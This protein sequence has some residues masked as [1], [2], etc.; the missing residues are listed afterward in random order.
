VSAV[1][2]TVDFV[3]DIVD[4]SINEK[5]E[6]FIVLV[7]V[8]RIANS[9]DTP[10]ESERLF[11][12]VTIGIDPNEPDKTRLLIT[13][14]SGGSATVSEGTTGW[15]LSLMIEAYPPEYDIEVSVAAGGTSTNP[16]MAGVDYNLSETSVTLTPGTSEYRVSLEI[17]NDEVPEPISESFLVTFS[18]M[19]ETV[20]FRP[21]AFVT[22]TIE[23]ND[24]LMM[25][26]SSSQLEIREGES[27]VARF[28]IMS[29]P[30]I[31]VSLSGSLAHASGQKTTA[32]GTEIPSPQSFSLSQTNRM[33]EF[34]VTIPQN[35]FITVKEREF[36]LTVQDIESMSNLYDVSQMYLRVTIK[37]NDT[38]IDV[39]IRDV[40]PDQP[41]RVRE[42]ESFTFTVGFLDDSV[43]LDDDFVL[44]YSLKINSNGPDEAT[45]FVTT[46][47]SD[48]LLTSTMRSRD[49][50][51]ETK[52][53]DKVEEKREF[54]INMELTT[55]FHPP[56]LVKFR[57]GSDFMVVII[58]DDDIDPPIKP[59]VNTV[60]V[61][62]VEDGKGFEISWTKNSSLVQ[63]V[64]TYRVEITFPAQGRIAEF[65]TSTTVDSKTT[66]LT[67]PYKQNGEDY[68]N[69]NITVVVCAVNSVG[70]TCSEEVYHKGIERGGTGQQGGS[71][72]SDGGIAAIVI[73]L[74]LLLCIG[75]L[76]LVLLLIYLYHPYGWRSYDPTKEEEKNGE[77]F[78]EARNE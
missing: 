49:I 28:F 57:A 72:V 18:V 31:D 74:L 30:T 10:E 22:I 73:V 13:A 47:I 40:S 6:Q 50:L 45:N 62:D 60:V 77:E 61:V 4:D 66:F 8:I 23:D 46:E 27:A 3:I 59:L 38:N 51:I 12:T 63:P 69:A 19:E 44:G 26:F 55:D 35:D 34:T 17:V 41:R 39:G 33:Y 67:V 75:I 25:G 24:R 1:R 58:E 78:L 48:G 11:A 68:S 54:L 7:E 56:S 70:E 15:Y 43:E 53:N 71:G 36:T 52:S 65:N 32:D 14:P 16:A 42:G 76:L 29:P 21:N 9:V 2:Q 5:E 64:D 37:D 20:E